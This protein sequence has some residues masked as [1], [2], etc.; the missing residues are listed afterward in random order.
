MIA[1]EEYITTFVTVCQAKNGP[2]EQA[3]L[4]VNPEVKAVVIDSPFSSAS[5]RP[6]LCG[7]DRQSNQDNFIE[8]EMPVPPLPSHFS[9]NH[10]V[11]VP[12]YYT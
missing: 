6:V 9:K 1:D 4:R 7:L 2:N 8:G 11:V 10:I 3:L 5:G 12:V